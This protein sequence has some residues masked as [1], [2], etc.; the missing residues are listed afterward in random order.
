MHAL[1]IINFVFLVIVCV[2]QMLPSLYKAPTAN[3]NL[4]VI[5]A[6]TSPSLAIS[7]PIHVK[8]VYYFKVF[9]PEPNN[10]VVKVLDFCF[11][12]R[13]NFSEKSCRQF[14]FFSMNVFVFGAE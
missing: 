1:N 12:C 6:F 14:A 4:V 2:L 3:V 10:Y 8:K 7:L 9:I 11:G 13:S 5:S